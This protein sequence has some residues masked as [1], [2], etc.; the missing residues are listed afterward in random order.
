MP[1]ATRGE[2]RRISVRFLPDEAL[3]FDQ[4][5]YT[6]SVPFGASSV[7]VWS[8]SRS[9][10]GVSPSS[11]RR[12]PAKKSVVRQRDRVVRCAVFRSDSDR[13]A[14]VRRGALG[15]GGH[16]LPPA[17]AGASAGV[18][19]SPL[20]SAALYMAI[21]DS[22]LAVPLAPFAAKVP[23]KVTPAQ[24]ATAA[25]AVAPPRVTRRWMLAFS[26]PA[27]PPGLVRGRAPSRSP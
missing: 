13:N 24:I 25:A 14:A 21:P 12:Y 20:S 17:G 6:L 11:S 8:Q 27:F 26:S 22:S 18:S 2:M 3:L 15:R 5:R 16:H 19:V 7:I 23:E 10:V 9:G 1:P 4:S